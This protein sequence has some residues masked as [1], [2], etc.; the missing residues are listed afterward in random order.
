MLSERIKLLLAETGAKQKDLALVAKVSKGTV[1][2]W[3]TGEIKTLRAE[4]AEAL[5]RAFGYSVAWLA[6][7]EGPKKDQ[8]DQRQSL[9]EIHASLCPEQQGQLEAFARY[10]ANQAKQDVLRPPQAA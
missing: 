9:L 10:L 7:G 4:Y 1:S 3:T 5:H 6:N 2:Q 8:T